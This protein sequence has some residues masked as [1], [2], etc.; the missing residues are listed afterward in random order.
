[1][2]KPVGPS[3][4]RAEPTPTPPLVPQPAPANS[5]WRKPWAIGGL[6]A[7]A[8]IA[9]VGIAWWLS[10]T[11]GNVRY[12]TAAVT[13]GDVTRAVVA[14]GTVNPVLTIIVGS[15]VSGTIQDVQCDFNT[16]VKQGQVC[17]KIDPRPYQTVVDQ[18]RANLVV[19]QAQ[20][21]KDKANL[22]Y[23]QVTYDRNVRLVQ[24]NAVSKDALDSAKSALDQA[25]AQIGVD[26]ATIE[27]RQAQLEAA[28]VNL[29]YTNIVSPVNGTVVARNVTIGQTVAA[30]FQ[31]PTL[32]L[33]ATDLTKMQVDTNVSES[34]IGGIKDG[35]KGYFTVD[36]FPNRNFQGAVSQV[37][38][39][40]QT[41]QNV[42]TYDVVVSVDNEDLALKPGMTAASRIVTD[43]RKGVL[44]VPSQ[45]LRFVPSG[46][47][48]P[49]TTQR[50]GASGPARQSA[51]PPSNQ[52]AVYVLRDGVPVKVPVTVGLDDDSR[53]E[54]VKGDL[55]QGERVIVTEQRGN[56]TASKPA[57]TAPRLQL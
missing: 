30:S 20:L 40:P 26:Q 10:G 24:T 12:A 15:Y 53:A 43:E 56:N 6:L 23:A 33:I 17:A 41:L 34:D 48:A 11:G 18:N 51:A 49:T 54:I 50:T 3:E 25:Q 21:A 36:A 16:Q 4:Q 2:N 28:Q 45:A 22:G 29:G 14:T 42:V 44:R 47:A 19:A 35:N 37:R 7:L 55:K 5:R 57:V 1:M 32:F 38:Q 52:G 9:A 27:L 39:A 31:T 46:A 13:R 8:V